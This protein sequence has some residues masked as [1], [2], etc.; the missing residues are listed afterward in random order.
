MPASDLL[1]HLLRHVDL[2]RSGDRDEDHLAHAAWGL[3]ALMH[4]EETRPDLM[5]LVD[6]AVNP[7]ADR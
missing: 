2:Y 3:F 5:D 1:N 6:F 7:G 4:F